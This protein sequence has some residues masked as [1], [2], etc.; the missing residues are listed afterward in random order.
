MGQPQLDY[1]AAELEKSKKANTTWQL[2]TS[3]TVMFNW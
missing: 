2:L 1:W 3:Q